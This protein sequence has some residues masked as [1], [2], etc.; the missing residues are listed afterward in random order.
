MY[1]SVL[2]LD[3]AV[4]IFFRN[5]LYISGHCLWFHKGG[6]GGPGQRL[7]LIG[8]GL[9][10]ESFEPPCIKMYETQLCCAHSSDTLW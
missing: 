1:L 9:G 2:Y 10:M 8:R 6:L 7:M 3:S 4:S 5:Y